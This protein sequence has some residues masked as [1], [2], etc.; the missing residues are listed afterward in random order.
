MYHGVVTFIEEYI[1]AVSSVS[2]LGD[3]EAQIMQ[4]MAFMRTF[5]NRYA[6]VYAVMSCQYRMKHADTYNSD[7]SI[8]GG[9]ELFINFGTGE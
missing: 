9:V 6:L 7:E 3:N 2:S 8:T 4:I 5:V 1:S